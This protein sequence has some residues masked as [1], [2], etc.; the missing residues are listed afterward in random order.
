M[1][2]LYPPC[3]PT[4]L[5]DPS[6]IAGEEIESSFRAHAL[7]SRRLCF[8]GGPPERGSLFPMQAK[9]FGSEVAGRSPSTLSLPTLPDESPSPSTSSRLLLLLNL[10]QPPSPTIPC[11]SA[12]SPSGNPRFPHSQLC[13]PPA[14][15]LEW[16]LPLMLVPEST[17]LHPGFLISTPPT[18]PLALSMPSCLVSPPRIPGSTPSITPCSFDHHRYHNLMCLTHMFG[19]GAHPSQCQRDSRGPQH[20]Q[21]SHQSQLVLHAPCSIRCYQSP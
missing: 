19:L 13:F 8:D 5:E 1:T 18:Q 9:R 21:D 10:S 11:D 3:F 14:W 4:D 17:E 6:G 20:L 16:P 2:R 12:L 7:G 15:C